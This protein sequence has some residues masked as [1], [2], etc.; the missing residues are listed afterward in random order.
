[1]AVNLNDKSGYTVNRFHI[2][3]VLDHIVQRLWG[4][5]ETGFGY[6]IVFWGPKGTVLF[7]AM[8]RCYVLL[9]FQHN[10]SD[11]PMHA[12]EKICTQSFFVSEQ[13]ISLGKQK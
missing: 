5:L 8:M 1:M 12:N 11:A 4:D 2:Y 7:C 10:Y 9:L 6:R 3:E 13:I